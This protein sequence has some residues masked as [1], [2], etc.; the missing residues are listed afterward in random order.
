[1]MAN[2]SGGALRS[3]AQIVPLEDNSNISSVSFILRKRTPVTARSHIWGKIGDIMSRYRLLRQEC[4]DPTCTQDRRKTQ[5]ES[6]F[7]YC[8]IICSVLEFL[9]PD[10]GT[11][12]RYSFCLWV[13]PTNTNV[14]IIPL[15]TGLKYIHTQSQSLSQAPR[16]KTRA[17]THT[18]AP[19][20]L[21]THKNSLTIEYILRR[22]TKNKTKQSKTKQSVIKFRAFH[23]CS[24]SDGTVAASNRKWTYSA[25]SVWQ[26]FEAWH[27]TETGLMDWCS[28]DLTDIL[29]RVHFKKGRR[30]LINACQALIFTVISQDRSFPQLFIRTLLNENDWWAAWFHSCGFACF[31]LL[32]TKAERF[33]SPSLWFFPKPPARITHCSVLEINTERFEKAVHDLVSSLNCSVTARFDAPFCNITLNVDGRFWKELC[34]SVLKDKYASREV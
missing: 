10:N 1:M 19:S 28:S 31:C 26:L 18:L 24:H 3:A 34:W 14:K 30:L 17:H 22:K 7:C 23:F 27:R 2:V 15:Q 6:V 8:F 33:S 13:Q 25:T 29:V 4:E 5:L 21:H 11:T 12:P 32:I 20:L 9:G 16:T